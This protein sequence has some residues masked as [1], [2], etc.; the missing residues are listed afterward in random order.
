[1]KKTE[2]ILIREARRDDWP[3]LERVVRAAWHDDYCTTAEVVLDIEDLED[4]LE[5]LREEFNS[6]GS[7]FL[8]AE[9]GGRVVGLAVAHARE[10]RIWIDD[11]FV[12]PEARRQ[13]IARA[14]VANCVV[15]DAEVRAEV[16]ARNAPALALF[17]EIGFAQSVETVLLKRPPKG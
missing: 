13:G 7:R 3:A 17:R 6:F 16:N 5:Y 4:K 9:D 8:V 11:L 1:M 2:P 15:D 12:G 14:L 10:G